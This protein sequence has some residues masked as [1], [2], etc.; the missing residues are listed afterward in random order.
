M[1]CTTT[2]TAT[3]LLF[4]PLPTPQFFDSLLPPP[5][6]PQFYSPSSPPQL[7]CFHHQN[8]KRLCRTSISSFHRHVTSSKEPSRFLRYKIH[9][10]T[11]LARGEEH[12]TYR[13][14]NG[15]AHSRKKMYRNLRPKF[16]PLGAKSCQASLRNK[17]AC[18]LFHFSVRTSVL[19][20]C[21]VKQKSL[22][23]F[24][25]QHNGEQ[26]KKTGD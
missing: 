18:S 16:S 21:T 24:S 22:L 4:S 20:F 15:V 17:S 23:K 26:N 3:I 2:T 8:H 11:L 6:P 10:C 19:D 5:P 25:D 14:K 7:Y 12:A 9:S 13:D 1:V